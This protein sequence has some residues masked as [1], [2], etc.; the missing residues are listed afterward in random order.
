MP[1]RRLQRKKD[2]CAALYATERPVTPRHTP[3]SI[4]HCVA[5]SPRRHAPT[6]SVTPVATT[7]A[8]A[9]PLSPPRPSY[10]T[11]FLLL[12]LS[13]PV[14][15][16][17]DLPEIDIAGA[18]MLYA[19][20]CAMSVTRWPARASVEA[21]RTARFVASRCHKEA[22]YAMRYGERLSGAVR[23][24]PATMMFASAA[25]YMTWR[26]EKSCCFR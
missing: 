21:R 6:F 23:L 13:D 5:V 18:P 20:P 16:C 1:G 24:T 4:R 8:H 12:P 25:R 22:R 15:P 11:L 19:A 2:A 14:S 3:Y 17:R 26:A 10:A 7:D 9:T